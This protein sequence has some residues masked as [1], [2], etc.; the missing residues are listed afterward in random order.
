MNG[1]GEYE[2]YGRNIRKFA[3][4][5]KDKRVIINKNNINPGSGVLL[6]IDSNI[7]HELNNFHQRIH[8]A[9]DK[10]LE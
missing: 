6:P 7:Y 3:N 10:V 2:E 5:Y 9:N 8:K 1:S 4:P